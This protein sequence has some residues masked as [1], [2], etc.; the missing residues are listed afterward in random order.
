MLRQ[1]RPFELTE[2]E[3]FHWWPF[4]TLMLLI[5]ANI[6]WTTL[7]RIPFRPV[8]FGVWMIHCGILTLIAGSLWYFSTKVEG[9]APVSRREV[10][11][12]I[13]S[14]DGASKGVGKILASPGN[15]TQLQVGAEKWS[16]QVASIDPNWKMQTADALGESAYSIMLIVDG[17]R[18]K[19]IRQVIAGRPDLAEDLLFTGNEQKP[20]ERAVK[21]KGSAIVEPLFGA[22]VEYA[23]QHWFYLKNDLEKS[24]A[25][26][27]R[28]P[29]D[30]AWCERPI[31]GLPFYNDYISD[32]SHIFS[33]AADQPID[34][35]EVAIPAVAANDPFPDI[36]FSAT[37]YLRY[38]VEQSR[39]ARGAVDSPLNPAM[40][41]R[42]ESSTGTIRD[43]TLAAFDPRARTSEGDLIRFRF[44]DSAAMLAE[45]SHEARV[46]FTLDGAGD[47]LLDLAAKPGADGFIP[48]GPVER[49]YGFKVAGAQDDMALSG[50]EVSVAI[51][52]MKTPHGQFRRWIFN[53]PALNRDMNAGDNPDPRSAPMSMAPELGA[54][55]LPGIGRI[56]ITLIAGPDPAQLTAVMA[57]TNETQVR[58]IAVGQ[59]LVVSEGTTLR[60]L[61]YL[62]RAVQ[63]VRPII[64]PMNQRVKDVGERSSMARIGTNDGET[65]WLRF[66]DYAFDRPEDVLR[67]RLFQPTRIRLADGSEAE[68]LFSRR[69]LPLPSAVALETF[70]LTSHVGGFT[71]QTSTIRDY[72][73]QLRFGKADGTWSAPQAVSVNQ[74]IEHDGLWFFQAQWDPPDAGQEGLPASAGLN[75]TVLGVGTREGVWLQLTGA[76][77][78]AIGMCYAFYVKP[79]IKRRAIEKTKNAA[80][81]RLHS[82]SA[83]TALLL[84]MS[85]VLCMGNRNASAQ[86]ILA[87][88]TTQSV[89]ADDVALMSQG[90]AITNDA[91]ARQVDLVPLEG[92]AIMS[93][94]RIKSLGSF[95][96]GY[97][98]DISFGTKIGAQPPLFTVLDLA[99]RPEAYQDADVI[100]VKNAE[101]RARLA[102]ALLQSDP[103]LQERMRGFQSHGMIS[104]SLLWLDQ[105][106]EKGEDMGTWQISVAPLMRQLSSDL[107][108]TS[109]QADQMRGAIALM[110]SDQIRA[111]LRAVPPT[112]LASAPVTASSSGGS[113]A[114]NTAQ[115]RA[116]QA[117]T[118]PSSQWQTLDD[119]TGATSAPWEQLQLAWRAGD[120]K[121][122]NAAAKNLA[123]AAANIDAAA[124]PSHQRLWW[125]SW[126][127]R[128]GQMTWTWFVFFGS[129][130]LLLLGVSWKWP[131]ARRAGMVVFAAAFIL[132]TAALLLRWYISDRWPNSNM[133]E[134]VTT[135]AWFGSCLAIVVEIILRRTAVSGLFALGAAVTSMTALM[136]CALAPVQLNPAISNMTPVLND[137]WLYIH[138]NVVIFSY[139]LIFMAAVSAALYL[140]WRWRGGAATYARIGGAGEMMSLMNSA[141]PAA[142]IR[143][144]RV[145]EI[146]DGVTMTLMELSFVLLW[147]GIAMGAIWA[148]HS[149]GRPWGWDPKEVFA[150]NTFVVFALLI[151]TRWRSKDKG[152]WTAVLAIIGAGVML[153]NWYVINFIITGLHSYA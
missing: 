65:K 93:E 48:I 19:F 38:A 73:S 9:D 53:D 43:F 3:W 83:L 52:D 21:A 89:A 117:N 63:E 139:A 102:Q 100:R 4:L 137:I 112:P 108:R 30:T 138:T 79:V 72:T 150:L 127:F 59:P 113:I 44:V 58:P 132:Q 76:I 64:V 134:A 87:S 133:F 128:T 98:Q 74:P 97:M 153:F 88:R 105:K 77:L 11:L 37:G 71:G 61:E 5:A 129:V 152:L 86:E 41:V 17:P 13:T 75:F 135:S 33:A 35:I 140:V 40:R 62:P 146:L 10:L 70:T 149:W 54:R 60:V 116:I 96:F 92:L 103:S 23:S 39:I 142:E 106:N 22:R 24:W 66:H 50:G 67:G 110:Q 81:I 141:V 7:R 122:V 147:S 57:I 69:R 68:I 27:V 145:G 45:C 56:P 28:K 20:V 51:V 109:K 36:T 46:Q 125:E 26:Y 34:P 121:G 12:E 148:D 84:M 8:N 42:V 1:W 2:F 143:A 82:P 49:G 90:D 95:S 80:Q 6:T 124:Y 136:A 119:A 104:R 101:V 78:A 16:V 144:N 47:I 120:A 111:R 18:Q 15:Q 29:G 32:R 114:A 131:W 123:T 107:I 126:Y 25:L 94:G 91:F 130:A 118:L 151:H 99:I 31:N 115:N 14:S 55:Y 85:T